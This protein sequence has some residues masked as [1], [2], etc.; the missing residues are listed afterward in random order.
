MLRV[1]G[2]ALADSVVRVVFHV[3]DADGDGSLTEEEFFSQYERH[4][5]G[6]RRGD[7]SG[8]SGLADCCRTCYARFRSG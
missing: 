5:R 2:I 7:V 6:D 8:L 3:F 4:V 1:C